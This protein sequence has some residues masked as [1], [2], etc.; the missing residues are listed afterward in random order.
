V[1][2]QEPAAQG[3]AALPL[4]ASTSFEAALARLD[5]IVEKLESGDL[6]LDQAVAAYEEGIKLARHCAG[7]LEATEKRVMQVLE[8]P[9]GQLSLVPLAEP[10]D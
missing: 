9:E 7:M 1:T 10:P 4:D 8:G 5:K 2:G 6:D 3:E